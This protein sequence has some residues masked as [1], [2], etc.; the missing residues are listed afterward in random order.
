MKTGIPTR[1]TR[2]LGPPPHIQTEFPLVC[3]KPQKTTGRRGTAHAWECHSSSASGW[4]MGGRNWMGLV[5][6]CQKKKKK[7]GLL[8]W[9]AVGNSA[10]YVSW[11]ARIHWKAREHRTGNGGRKISPFQCLVI[12]LQILRSGLRHKEFWWGGGWGSHAVIKNKT[13]LGL[14]VPNSPYPAL[15]F[16]FFFYSPYHL[17]T[18]NISC[19]YAILGL[20]R[21]HGI[22]L[23]FVRPKCLGQC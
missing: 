8:R 22:D 2:K 15:L 12:F 16:F 1:E 4:V 14:R 19:H 13:K 21:T 10:M 9:V 5:L 17:L 6:T 7:L 20:T 18:Y 23:C 11:A 3:P